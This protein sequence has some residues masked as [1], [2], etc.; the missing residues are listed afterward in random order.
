MLC[1]LSPAPPSFVHPSQVYPLTA[2][3]SRQCIKVHTLYTILAH[4]KSHVAFAS[5]LRLVVVALVQVHLSQATS[6]TCAYQILNFLCV[7][8]VAPYFLFTK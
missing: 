8:V 2:R 1:S 3:L 6:K 5:Q 4:H 7:H